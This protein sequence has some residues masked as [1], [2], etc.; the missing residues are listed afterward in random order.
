MREL[1]LFVVAVRNLA[2]RGPLGDAM[3]RSDF[4]TKFKII[5]H[6]TK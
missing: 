4:Y 1:V 2:A 6:N 5:G 3:E